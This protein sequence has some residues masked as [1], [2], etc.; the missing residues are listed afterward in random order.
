MNFKPITYLL[1][2]K[3]QANSLTR[4]IDQLPLNEDHPLEVLIREHVKQRTPSQNRY[5]WMRLGEIAVQAWLEGRQYADKAWHKVCAKDLMPEMIITK[6]GFLESKWID[7]P[8][9]GGTALKYAKTQQIKELLKVAG[10]T[11]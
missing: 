5:Y 10:A 9:G 8:N 3:I 6:D 7:L 1:R 4:L 2:T 11:K